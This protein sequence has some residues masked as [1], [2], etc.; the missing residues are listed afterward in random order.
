MTVRKRA[1]N[2]LKT[3]R[4]AADRADHEAERLARRL[5]RE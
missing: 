2:E 5:S 3:A 4:A 1:D